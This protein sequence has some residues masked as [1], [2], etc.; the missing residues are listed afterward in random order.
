MISFDA[1]HKAVHYPPDRRFRIWIKPPFI[2]A[3]FCLA[4]IALGFAWGQ[5]ALFGLPYIPPVP[6]YSEASP[7]G[8]HGFPL[9]VRYCHFLNFLFI[10][11]LVRSG[12]SILMDH[13]RLYFN[14]DCTPG[15]EWIRFT[16]LQ[17]PKD[18]IWTAKDD[19]RY[20]SPLVA[21]PGCRHT[22]GIA[23]SWHFLDVYGFIFTGFI[24]TGL[25]FAT[26]QWRR[27]VPTSPDV[28]G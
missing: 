13:P 2:A 6:L 11:M 16:P 27:I 1:A 22:V 10:T 7:S 14:D 25:L 18:R 3:A 20:I 12:L 23:R 4:F 9:W 24:F 28:L 19:A 15:T 21:T 8:P 17:V 26:N 5:A